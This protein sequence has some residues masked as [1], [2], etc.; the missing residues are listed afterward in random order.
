VTADFAAM[1]PP[2][3]RKLAL[4]TYPFQRQRYWPQPSRKRP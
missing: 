2:Q 3:R 4:P 1:H